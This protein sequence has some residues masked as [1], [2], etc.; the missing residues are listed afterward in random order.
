MGDQSSLLLAS[1]L[2]REPVMPDPAAVSARLA[3]R[4]GGRYTVSWDEAEGE[5]DITLSCSV[6]GHTVVLGL[7][8][9]P[10]PAADLEAACA[11]NPFWPEAA[12]VCRQHRAHLMVTLMKGWGDPIRRHLVL[13]DF[14]AALS[15]AVGGLA[16]LWGPVGVLQSAEY[17][18]EQAA[19]ASADH[20]PLFLW[21]EFALVRHD[22]VP[23]VATYGLDAFGVMEVEGG[24]SRMKPIQLLE[25]VFD[26]AHY[27]CLEGPV[28]ND[29]DTIGGSERERIPVR[30]TDSI[31]DR[32][33]PVIRIEFDAAGGRRGLLSR[34]FGR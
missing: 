13:T 25:R 21:V 4:C 26:V 1:L 31:L 16:V 11:R 32:P 29:G 34:L 9:A 27:L 28:L 22:G 2:L 30:H 33:G 19:E 8:R 17:F 7:M 10:V 15:E 5:G 24:S 18:R 12:E 6:S 20:L 23:F 14:V 3:A